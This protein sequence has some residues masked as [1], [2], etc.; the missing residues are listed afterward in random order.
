MILK[1][2]HSMQRKTNNSILS[3][4]FLTFYSMTKKTEPPKIFEPTIFL[5]DDVVIIST[6]RSTSNGQQDALF[7]S[8]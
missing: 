4:V 7:N 6:D 2:K 1:I 3:H 8:R 5:D